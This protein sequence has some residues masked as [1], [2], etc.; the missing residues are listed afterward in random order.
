[1]RNA[2]EIRT[3]RHVVYNLHTHLVFVCKYRKT[4]LT[5]TMLDYLKE[6]FYSVCNDMG[7]ELIEFDGE[8]DH[9]HLMVHYPP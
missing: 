2:T 7:A 1:M 8:Q 5:K 4:V 9:V 6:V 3:G